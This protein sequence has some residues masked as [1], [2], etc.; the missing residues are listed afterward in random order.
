MKWVSGIAL[1]VVILSGCARVAHVQKDEN[2]DFNSIKSYA[3][4][5][6][7]ATKNNNNAENK[8]VTNDLTNRKIR[9]SIDKNLQLK[10]WREVKQNPDVFLVT[11]VAVEK[12]D[13]SVS[14][15]VYTQPQTRWFYNPYG[16]RWV[17]VF[18]PS[19]FLGYDNDT[20]TV[21][22]A[23]LT[24][25]MMDASND[26]TIWQGWTYSDLNGKRL[27]DREIDENVKAI[28]KKLSK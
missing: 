9:Q 8:A 16:R 27:S 19:Q 24:L 17:P 14:T 23:T 26:K 18:Y 2:V 3:W 4:A 20:R 12:E 25:T 21:N 5:D 15:P 28:V 1:S 13:R 11:D 6:T 22:E 10:G 7:Y